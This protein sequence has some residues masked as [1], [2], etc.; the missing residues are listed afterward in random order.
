MAYN[1]SRLTELCYHYRWIRKCRLWKEERSKG[2]MYVYLRISHVWWQTQEKSLKNKWFLCIFIVDFY[3]LSG[4]Q[5]NFLSPLFFPSFEGNIG[6]R[7]K[8]ATQAEELLIFIVHVNFC[9]LTFII[10]LPLLLAICLSI[11]QG[12]VKVRK[13]PWTA[14]PE[15]RRLSWFV[16]CRFAELCW[17]CC[18]ND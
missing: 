1:F 7:A 10:C 2:E 8:Y 5:I 16:S 11:I 12:P 6:N 13:K 9:C 3:D 14:H 18:R 17:C 15:Q 4:N